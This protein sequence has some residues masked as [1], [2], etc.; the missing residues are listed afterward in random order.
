MWNIFDKDLYNQTWVLLFAFSWREPAILES[1]CEAGETQEEVQGETQSQEGAQ[2]Q[3]GE[4]GTSEKRFILG[5]PGTPAPVPHWLGRVAY[6]LRLPGFDPGSDHFCMSSPSL[7][8]LHFRLLFYSRRRRTRS[9]NTKGRRRIRRRWS[10][11]APLTKA[12]RT[13]KKT[14]TLGGRLQKSCSKGHRSSLAVARKDSRKCSCISTVLCFNF[15]YIVFSFCSRLKN[16]SGQKWTWISGGTIC[17][18]W[19]LLMFVLWILYCSV[20]FNT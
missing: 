4:K 13:V 5:H 19:G 12:K 2:T 7:S 17:P 1:L 15:K 8:P 11:S 16:I 18:L 14:E 6:Q 9:K 10:S 3:E 20:L